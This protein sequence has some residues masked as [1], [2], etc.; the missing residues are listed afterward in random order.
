M[1]TGVNL[2][3][4]PTLVMAPLGRTDAGRSSGAALFGDPPPPVRLVLRALVQVRDT[5]TST[6]AL[7]S[8]SKIR[9]SRVD[10]SGPAHGCVRRLVQGV[11]GEMRPVSYGFEVAGGAA[12]PVDA[13][14][15][16]HA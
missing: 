14:L 11:R 8:A 10:F 2:A 5:V 12:R 3:C 15:H 1:H 4:E 7:T 16:A 6:F 13:S 9:A